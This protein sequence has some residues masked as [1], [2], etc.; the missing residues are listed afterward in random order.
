MAEQ[1]GRERWKWG[2][3]TGRRFG[4]C[5]RPKKN[6][7]GGG[8]C[9]IFI[10]LYIC[11][12]I[13]CVVGTIK[14]MKAKRIYIL[15]I[16]MLL[17]CGSVWCQTL[18][19]MGTDFWFAFMGGVPSESGT[20]SVTVTGP[21]ACSGSIVRQT[22]GRQW[23]FE[24][25]ANGST[26]I[27]LTDTQN[28]MEITS[29]A[30]A[31][32][33]SFHL[34]TTDTV[35]VYTSNFFPATF[36]ASFVLPTSVLRDEY[37]VQTW[38]SDQSSW[39]S[40]FLVLAVQNNTVVD[41]LPTA[42]CV[43]GVYQGIPFT[44]SLQQGQCMLLKSRNSG[45]DFSGTTIKARNCKPIAVINGNVNVRI[46]ATALYGDR[47]YE[48][49]V[50]TAYWGK[51]F[52]LTR[53]GYHD[54]DR[55]KCTALQ[56]DCELRID[57][58]VVDTVDAGESYIFTLNVAR[59]TASLM[60]SKPVCVYSYMVSKNFYIPH[61]DPSMV[62]EAPIEQQLN[63]V[64]FVNY[65]HTGQLTS[66]FFVNVCTRTDNVQ[67]IYLDGECIGDLFQVVEG[68]PDYSYAIVSST[69]G[70]HRLQ[71]LGPTGFV[72]RSYGVGQNESFG[73]S[74]GFAARIQKIWMSVNDRINM[75]VNDT[76]HICLG[77]SVFFVAGSNTGYD[78]IGWNFGDGNTAS[79]NN[80]VHYYDSAG[81]Y[82]AEVTLKRS[83]TDCFDADDSSLVATV[84][85]YVMVH[86]PFFA[87]QDSA[88]CDSLMFKDI[89]YY[90]D[91]VDSSLYAS[92]FGCDSTVVTTL[93]V[94]RSAETSLNVNVYEG[95]SLIWIDGNTYNDSVTSG[96]AILQTSKGC[97]SIVHLNL[98]L[99]QRPELP[100][101]DS[102][103]LWVPNAFTPDESSNNRFRV[104]GYD[105]LSVKVYVF[106]RW[107]LKVAEFDG[108]T[109]EW[110]GSFEGK[111]CPSGAY[112][113]LVNYVKK[114][115]PND[116]HHKKGTILLIR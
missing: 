11:I 17:L 108:L 91:A 48:Q 102:F 112:T 94:N 115:S 87:S 42:S 76:T 53:S 26:T 6:M 111:P 104:F 9:S 52:V 19:T 54:G 79:E 46:P 77:D 4:V 14:G 12:L 68:K 73:Y 7:L 80:I 89:M 99:L 23:D 71:S 74:V 62:F 70:S 60:C 61:G 92:A 98:N 51:E 83:G 22:D 3:I 33:K 107:G 58:S 95:D 36:D 109:Q 44:I 8:R 40:Q 82:Y 57:G 116:T 69:A 56:D 72:G 13:V 84:G 113:Y 45:E 101:V 81:L 10:F 5:W 43:N 55:V 28:Q 106:N 59:P 64:V 103:A 85:S 63:D 15:L 47:L 93:T 20:L 65:N 105:L 49:A 16:G 18:T 29:S 100:V 39:P 21:R 66:Y 35:S 1:V 27:D 96:T 32:S 38:H 24:V 78:S 41:I 2:L 50:P 31:V 90:S 25:P 97:D 67:N 34:T 88:S 110:D 114:A 86:A 37:M 75:T 30:S